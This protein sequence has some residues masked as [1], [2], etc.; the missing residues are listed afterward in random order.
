[1]GRNLPRRCS[2][3]HL[4]RIGKVPFHLNMHTLNTQ[5]I[6]DYFHTFRMLARMVRR[7][8]L[9]WGSSRCCIMR[10]WLCCR[11]WYNC[12]YRWDKLCRRRWLRSLFRGRRIPRRRLRKVIGIKCRR[13]HRIGYRVLGKLET[14]I[15]HF[16]PLSSQLSRRCSWWMC[17]TLR[18]S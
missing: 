7:W 15:R 11:S 12:W 16:R 3:K 6:Q 8:R 14:R 13:V 18:S 9:V 1:M 17:C 2:Y 4:D 10:I 5:Y